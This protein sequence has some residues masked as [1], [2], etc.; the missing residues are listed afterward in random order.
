M[1]I[2]TLFLLVAL[3][4]VSCGKKEY[5]CQCQD[6]STG[7]VLYEMHIEGTRS[8]AKSECAKYSDEPK[9]ALGGNQTLCEL[10]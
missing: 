2:A 8:Y 5:L 1:K 9:I 10:K 3:S 6:S 7:N 4:T